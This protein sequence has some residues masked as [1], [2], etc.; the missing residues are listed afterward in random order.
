MKLQR[1][2]APIGL[3][4]T[5]FLLIAAQG[6]GCFGLGPDAP[7]DEPPPAVVENEPANNDGGDG[8]NNGG[9][10]DC[11][12]RC[13]EAGADEEAC[14]R[15]CSGERERNCLELCA[16]A[17]ADEEACE[18][19]CGGADEQ[20]ECSRVCRQRAGAFYEACVD[21]GRSPEDCRE[22]AGEM[23]RDCVANRCEDG[24]DEDDA[25]EGRCRERAAAG[26]EA[27][28]EAG[29]EPG[30]C[31]AQA[32]DQFE[33][34]VE[35]ACGGEG[36]EEDEPAECEVACRERAAWVYERCVDEGG[37]VADC[38]ARAAA[39]NDD[40]LASRCEDEE[41]EPAACEVACRERA[42]AVNRACLD[43]GG[44]AR[45]C[46]ERYGAALEDCMARNCA[47]E[48]GGEDRPRRCREAA[49]CERGERCADNLCVG[50]D[51]GGDPDACENR[52]RERALAAQEACLEDLGEEG[53]RDCRERYVAAFEE[54]MTAVCQEHEEDPIDPCE[55]RC[56]ERALAVHEACL[57]A[58]GEEGARDCRERYAAAFEDCVDQACGEDD[59]D[60]EVRRC[61]EAG[62]CERGE[63]CIDN[64]CV[65]PEDAPQRCRE[66]ADCERGE[67]CIDNLCVGAEDA[68]RRCREAADCEAGRCVDGVCR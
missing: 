8:E 10:G 48:G 24:E 2:L 51:E 3:A 49:D 16:E 54:C 14:E 23:S 13:A 61:R 11:L 1:H 39:A 37:E 67:R 56:R 12:E 21:E 20:E 32:G 62:D 29:G 43:E 15:R 59:D 44:D 68:P 33:A 47:D 6:G 65:G 55:N 46:R 38:R 66:A 58:L 28:V 64:L 5:G 19:R 53:A 4:C 50:P 42:T 17:G 36:G 35:R 7:A 57:E 27:C 18:R 9:E 60:E 25:C 26:Y 31:R 52:C 30:D 40:C 63:R 41:D 22:R 45:A 34:C